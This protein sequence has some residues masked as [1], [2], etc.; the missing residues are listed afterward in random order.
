LILFWQGHGRKALPQLEES[1]RLFRLLGEQNSASIVEIELG[2]VHRRLGE[3]QTAAQ[4]YDDALKNLKQ[5]G[6]TGWRAQLLNNIGF[7]KYMTG[8]FEEAHQLLNEA[9]QI[10]ELCGYVRIKTNALTSLG[11]LLTD[12][13]DLESALSCYDQALTHASH[14]GHSR[15]IFY[16]SLGESRLRR[17]KG[18]AKHALAELRQVELSQV[19]LGSYERAFFNLE[20][21]LCLL[22]LNQV[23]DALP[24]FRSAQSLFE[25][26]GNLAEQLVARLWAEISQAV[27]HGNES[28]HELV[29]PQRE[30]RKPSFLMLHAGRAAR[31]LKLKK[32]TRLLKKTSLRL[33]FEHASRLLDAMSDLR[34]RLQRP[35]KELGSDSPRLEINSFGTVQVRHDGRVLEISD[36]QTREARDLFLFLLQSPPRTKEQIA[37]DFWPDL[38]PTR[39]KMRFK[40]NMYRIRKAL[41]Q[42]AVIF[43]DEYYGFNR[44]IPYKWDRERF[45]EL[46]NEI[47]K[48]STVSRRIEA[49]EEMLSLVQGRYLE[50]LDAPW[51]EADRIQYENHR[52]T[53]MLDLAELYLDSGRGRDC[54]NTVKEL[55]KLEP[56]M[57]FAHRLMLRAY[58]A[59][60]DPVGLSNHYRQYQELLDAELG[61]LPS[62]EMR[63]LY[64]TLLNEV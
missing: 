8:E 20:Q 57:E 58:A 6:M 29:P 24:V 16:A 54:L 23:E 31:W 64:E 39:L 46:L 43:Q 55:I 49:L 60:H 2:A 52:K 44:S 19:S 62:L 27:T 61:M 45:D 37:A 59:L 21:G 33:F 12:L 38:P 13:G 35:V 34:D 15:Y 11:D 10:A 3:I 7:M 56:L 28:I 4:Y 53:I 32:Q 14:L 17:L 51:A 1:H 5:A 48:Q 40:I 63:T 50:D 42:D 47:G 25:E 41:G 18:D 30:W 9:I 36:W 26:S 22:E